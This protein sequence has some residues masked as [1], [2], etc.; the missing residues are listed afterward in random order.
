MDLIDLIEHLELNQERL[1]SF[2]PEK[3]RPYLKKLETDERGILFYGPRGV[4]KTTFLLSKTHRNF[5]YLSGD[6][7]LVSSVSLYELGNKIF[8]KGYDGIIVD[9]IHF[10]NNWTQHVKS[11]YDSFPDKKIWL[12][13]SSSL[14]LRMG[15]FDLSRRFLKIHVPL[16]SFREF[17]YLKS[18]IE[19]PVIDPF[20]FEKEKINEMI[21]NYK[22]I[23]L[24]NEYL[25]TGTRPLFLEGNFDEKMLNILEKTLYQDIPFFLQTIKDSYLRLMNAVVGLLVTSKI[26]TLNVESLCK[27]WSIG[28]E[29]LYQLLEVLKETE[30]INI[31]RKFNDKKAYSKGEKIF[32]HDPS[33]YYI[34]DGEVGNAREAYVSSTLGE[35]EKIYASRDERECD[36]LWKNKKIEVGGKNKKQK[37]SD[38]VLSDELDLPVKN[39]IPLWMLGL[40]R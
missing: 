10:V 26:P 16:L 25:S 23:H 19:L 17:C 24:F 5:L 12:S 15:T 36:F 1:T 3:L 38:Y 4:G 28:K 20:N 39:R 9:E 6:N 22:I 18:D 13:D 32:M 35:F 14:I 34:L 31:I 7:P 27:D 29:K 2:L 37:Q 8:L 33:F 21:R 40:M 30:I 11:L